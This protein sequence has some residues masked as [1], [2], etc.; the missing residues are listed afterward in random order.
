M[1]FL[2][3]KKIRENGYLL[4]L[5]VVVFVVLIGIGMSIAAVVSSKYAASRQGVYSTNA[6]YAAE[7]GVSD[8]IA[9]LNMNTS[10][11]GFSS[12]KTFADSGDR[13]RSVYT[14]SVVPE[15]GGALAIISEGATYRSSGDTVRNNTKKIRVIVTQQR[16]PVTGISLMAG[17]GGLKMDSFS[18]VTTGGGSLYVLGNVQTNWAANSSIG[19]AAKPLSL[20]VANI[21]CGTANW[22]ER[23]VPASD[24]IYGTSGFNGAIYGTVCANDNVSG[25]DIFAS[26]PDHVG[27]IAN[28]SPPRA[29]MPSFDKKAF[30]DTIKASST[31]VSA[32]SF[33]CPFAWTEH[34]IDIPANSWIEGDLAPSMA[35]GCVLRIKG[36]VYLDGNLSVG[37]YG[38]I[39][40][41]DSVGAN[42]PKIIVNGRV[43]VG[44]AANNVSG[45]Q[46]SIGFGANNVGTVADIISFQSTNTT[47]SRNETIP[48]S[49]VASCLSVVESKAS[50][51]LDGS[52]ANRALSC[53]GGSGIGAN[54]S[55]AT[56][57]AYYGTV[58]CSQPFTIQSVGGQGVRAGFRA[59][60]SLLDTA[61]K[62]FGNGFWWRDYGV[63]DYQQVY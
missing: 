9:R 59:N 34:Y 29:T 22:P 53:S 20:T 12:E 4:P 10:F 23:C 60:L 46:R 47:C 27:R 13:G 57:Y 42:R 16:T 55:G 5:T 19:T 63:V 7:A 11:T 49:T 45:P 58:Y 62:S 28:C 25:T 56:F 51:D 3:I 54:F 26:P 36:D 41:D 61:G 43:V 1:S 35:Y 50:A 17:A 15:S 30:I 24:S 6:L 33:N 37:S 21:A 48:S 38:A 18:H 31:K 40:V 52:S 44:D 2:R 8:T 32:A 14:T 39:A